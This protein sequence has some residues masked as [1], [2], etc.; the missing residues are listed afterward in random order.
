MFNA[1]C[2]N[3]DGG[4]DSDITWKCG[5]LDNTTSSRLDQAGHPTSYLTVPFG[6]QSSG[7]SATLTSHDIPVSFSD[8]S[9]NNSYGISENVHSFDAP[10][11]PLGNDAHYMHSLDQNHSN[12][13]FAPYVPASDPGQFFP[14][15]HPSYAPDWPPSAPATINPAVT[16]FYPGGSGD[17]FVPVPSCPSVLLGDSLTPPPIAPSVDP[18]S[19]PSNEPEPNPGRVEVNHQGD[20]SQEQVVSRAKQTKVKQCLICL[21]WIESKPSSWTVG[22]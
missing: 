14:H 4:G 17:P 20:G 18:A 2:D 22:A 9:A 19:M 10:M 16:Q 11:Q 12:T 13:D 8:D 1:P 7:S 5:P 21:K 3:F 6:L 15:A